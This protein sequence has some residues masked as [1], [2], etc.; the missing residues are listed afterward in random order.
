MARIDENSLYGRLGRFESIAQ[1]AEGI[2]GRMMRDSELGLYFKGHNAA[3]K[4]RLQWQFVAY[5]VQ[6]MGG[7]EAYCGV[8]MKTAHLGLGISEADWDRFRRIILEAVE[9]YRVANPEQAEMTRLIDELKS[10]I[11]EC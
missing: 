9:K 8:D 4:K 1:L 3:G 6:A 7:P 10:E 11:V 2:C 5:L